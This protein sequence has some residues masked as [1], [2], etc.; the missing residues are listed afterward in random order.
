MSGVLVR[1]L[2]VLPL[3]VLGVVTVVFVLARLLP[4][5]PA[6]LAAGPLATAQQVATIRRQLG[7]DRSIPAQ[8]FDYIG[9]AARGDLGV[10]IY[11]GNPVTTDL[12]QRAGATL[13][14]ITVA[15]GGMVFLTVV[16]TSAIAMARGGVARRAIAT[17]GFIAGSLPDF[18]IGLA[19]IYLIYYLAAIG[20][21]PR[22]QLDPNYQ[23]AT[24]TGAALVD[25]LVAGNGAAFANAVQHLILPA[26]TLIVVYSAPVVRITGAA[27]TRSLEGEA[28]AY[29]ESWGIRP[30]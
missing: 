24:V 25:T 30:W 12:R 26:V 1:R 21:P 29:A 7:L 23:V 16:V 13:E 22:G 15:L 4:G 17:Y 18:W 3:Q 8:Y 6:H 11:T 2:A 10:S 28:I 5:D 19:L 20:P 27:V 9:K 14:L